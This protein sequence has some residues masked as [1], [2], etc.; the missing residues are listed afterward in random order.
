[1]GHT[2]AETPG[3]SDL[4]IAILVERHMEHTHSV[5]KSDNREIPLVYSA[6]FY[7][8]VEYRSAADV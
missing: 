2:D 6:A 3:G 8:V 7:I 1:M 4:A 5:V